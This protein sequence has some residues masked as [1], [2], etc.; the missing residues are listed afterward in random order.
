MKQKLLD[1]LRLL[2]SIAPVT[3]LMPLSASAQTSIAVVS[4]IHVMAPDLL[5]NDAASNEPWIKDF[6]GERKMLDKSAGLFT[7]FVGALKLSKPD[8]LL[9]TGDLTKDGE[10]ASHKY[11]RDGLAELTASPYNIKVFVIPGNHDIK[12]SGT[13]YKYDGTTKTALTEDDLITTDDAFATYYNG[14]GYDDDNSAYDTDS[15]SYATEPVPGL[16]IIGIDS[17]STTISDETLTWI[18]SQASQARDKGKQVIAMMHHPLFPHITGADMFIDTYTVGS[19]ETV[20]DALID[21]GVN[22][23]LT[24]HFHTSDIAKDWKTAE[25]T[26]PIYDINTGSLI[27]YPCDYRMLTLSQNKQTLNVSTYSLT[28]SGMTAD[29]CKTWLSDRVEKIAKNKLNSAP[30]NSLGISDEDKVFLAETAASAFILHAEGDENTNGAASTLL[31][32]YETHPFTTTNYLFVLGKNIYLDPTFNSI[33]TDKS[34]YGG[35]HQNQT[36]DRTLE[37]PMPSLDESVTIPASGWATYCTGHD[38][39]V[40]L[41]SGLTAYTVTAVDATT[42]TLTQVTKIPAEEGFLLK[43]TAG[44]YTLKPATE[45]VTAV[46]NLLKGTLTATVAVAGDYA[47]ATKG[48]GEN[49]VTAFYPVK[50]GVTIPARKAYFHGTSG[51]PMLVLGGDGG[52]TGIETIGNAPGSKADCP[53]YTL[54]GTRTASLRP[55]I[56]IRNGKKLVIK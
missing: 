30:Y 40:S 3:L 17:H 14:Y 47:L 11:V 55:G 26:D 39:D 38:V 20:R 36:P 41:T 23:I 49:Q 9:I 1:N 42:A 43:G 6:A 8:I 19:Y 54:Q 44:N 15:K 12:S 33:L 48:E 10:L 51:A 21:A 4:D 35:D 45:A 50:A 25:E 16:V 31:N 18:C 37:I 27:S 7:Q 5:A 28:P 29:A 13:V 32:N 52:A 56:Y 53:V 24:G 2:L 34:N 46:T 22:V